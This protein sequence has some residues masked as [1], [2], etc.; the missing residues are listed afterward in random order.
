MVNESPTE[1]HGSRYIASG[2]PITAP[3]DVAE[4]AEVA[5]VAVIFQ[6]LH[7]LHRLHRLKGKTLHQST[8]TEVRVAASI[9]NTGNATII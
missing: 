9:N 8:R 2:M 3:A 7:R 5:E 4:V 6:R 1:G